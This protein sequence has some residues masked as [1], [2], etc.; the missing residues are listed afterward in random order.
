MDLSVRG[1][2]ALDFL[3]QLQLRRFLGETKLL[4]LPLHHFVPAVLS[5]MHG[6]GTVAE[7]TR[8]RHKV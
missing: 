1:L 7:E 3:A 6:T 4:H 5:C 2:H 8:R